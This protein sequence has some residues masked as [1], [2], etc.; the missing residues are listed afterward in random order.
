MT[1]EELKT[2]SARVNTAN[3]IKSTIRSLSDLLETLRKTNTRLGYV[4]NCSIYNFPD[5]LSSDIKDYA[6]VAIEAKIA[7]LKS[8]Y[9]KL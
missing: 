6:I 3:S 9:D 1:D 8:Q 7:R 2:L 5:F 4:S